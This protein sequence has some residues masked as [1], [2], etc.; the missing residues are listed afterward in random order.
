MRER[1]ERVSITYVGFEIGGGAIQCQIAFVGLLVKG[2]NAIVL[3][4]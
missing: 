3:A 4:R 1:R 2:E